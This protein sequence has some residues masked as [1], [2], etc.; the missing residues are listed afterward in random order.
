MIVVST[1]NLDDKRIKEYLGIVVG[2]T[3]RARNVG[4]D[5]LAALKN[6]VGGELQ[7]YSK[8][9]AAARQE[10][11]ERMTQN[12]IE[13]GANA[14]INFRFQTSTISHGASEVIAYGTAV[15]IEN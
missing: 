5:I 11:L 4:S 10:A 8:L 12:A 3:V 1:P 2:G 9:L 13:L 14:V 15:I 7:S 6:L